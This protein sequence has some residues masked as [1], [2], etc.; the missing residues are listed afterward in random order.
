MTC[1]IKYYQKCLEIYEILTSGRDSCP[2]VRD[3]CM[4]SLLM[5]YSANSGN[6]LDFLDFL[7]LDIPKWVYPNILK[8]KQCMNPFWHLVKFVVSVPVI[9]PDCQKWH[10]H[11]MLNVEEETAE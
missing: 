8:W 5:I 10:I 7:E 11:G 3:Y 9:L 1:K 2:A 6:V 4:F